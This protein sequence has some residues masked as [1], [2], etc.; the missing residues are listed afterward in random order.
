MFALETLTPQQLEDE[1]AAQAAHVDAGL[2]RLLELVADCD[3]RVVTRDSFA[4]WLAWRCSLLPRQAREFERVAACLTELP[5]IRAA[6]GRGELS[7]AKV[8]A[9]T[10]IA[11]PDSEEKLLE[12]AEVLTASQLER[13]V[14]AFRRLTREQA[15]DQH[16]REFFHYFWTEDGSLEL[17]G[18]L[19][20][21][22]GALLLR[23]LESARELLR[24]RQRLES[25][26]PTRATNAEAL[27]GVAELA[28]AAPEADRSGGDR[29]QIVVHVDANVLAA[30]AGGRCE[31]DEGHPLAAETARRLAC[32]SSLV[33]GDGRKRRTI[34]PPLRRALT[35]RDRGCRFPGCER[36]RFVDAHHVEHWANGGATKLDNLLTL[37]RRHH[38]LVHEVGYTV[39]FAENGEVIF[40]NQHGIVVPSVPRPPPSGSDA[41]RHLHQ[42]L[43]IDH[44]TTENGTGERMQLAYVVDAV[45]GALN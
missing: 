42:D 13:A 19:S 1:L 20:A 45:V 7:Y 39:E 36:T 32:D 33:T 26:E 3:R 10:R 29:Y 8:C 21:D 40:K 44:D 24:A 17:S 34:S 25:E 27:V 28:L 31:L 30:D 14:G 5:L 15:A 43:D 41:L 38:R 16:A 2:A 18:R 22:E 6:F 11:E 9:L 4:T 37:C 23:A 35:A 12:L